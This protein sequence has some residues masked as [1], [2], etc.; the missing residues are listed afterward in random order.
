MAPAA[1]RSWLLGRLAAKEA[2]GR[3]WNLPPAAVEVLKGPDGAPVAASSQRALAVGCLS[4]SHTS[5]AAVAVAAETPVGVDLERLDRPVSPRA[6]RWAFSPA[7]QKMLEEADGGYPPELALWC[8]KEAAAK[9]WGRGLLNHLNQVRVLQADWPAGRITVG[10]LPDETPADG[11]TEDF[12][13]GSGPDRAEV[14]LMI[15]D[16]FLA[17]LAEKAGPG[18]GMR[19]PRAAFG[20]GRTPDDRGPDGLT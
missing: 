1:H 15:Y 6:W 11:A 7:E 8:A 9:S 14:Q 17:A 5:D 19:T 20:P 3:L 12:P 4:I 10:W 13:D 16:R 2:V 18:Q